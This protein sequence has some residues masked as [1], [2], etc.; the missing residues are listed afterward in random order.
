[1]EWKAAAGMYHSS[2]LMGALHVGPQWSRQPRTTANLVQKTFF[3][4]IAS[5]SSFAC[6]YCERLGS[7]GH[8]ATLLIKV[9]QANSHPPL[10]SLSFN[11]RNIIHQKSHL[12]YSF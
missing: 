8:Q 2:L 3:N 10:Q 6:S 7:P 9:N 4:Q 1:L 12:N 11:D 5:I